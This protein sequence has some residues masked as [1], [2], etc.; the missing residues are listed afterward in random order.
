MT[1]PQRGFLMR[2]ISSSRC[3]PGVLGAF[4]GGIAFSM[5]RY[6]RY[7]HLAAS[8]AYSI[9]GK[10]PP[11]LSYQ[12]GIKPWS[13]VLPQE[14]SSALGHSIQVAAV[15]WLLRRLCWADG[16]WAHPHAAARGSDLQQSVC[17]VRGE[18]PCAAPH[19]AL[20][21]DAC[22]AAEFSGGKPCVC[23]RCAPTLHVSSC[24]RRMRTSTKL[25]LQQ[26]SDKHYLQQCCMVQCSAE[27]T[28]EQE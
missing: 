16:V 7:F 27:P 14:E 2:R 19:A 13:M 17:S 12:P 8:A 24:S 23:A 18:Q 21:A 20:P 5:H 1:K 22:T 28:S 26:L 11:S 3:V 10:L 6:F 15:A 9:S 25:Q 4:S